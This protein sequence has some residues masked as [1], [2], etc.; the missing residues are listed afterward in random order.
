MFYG[1]HKKGDLFT[2]SVNTLLF[3]DT[4][5]VNRVLKVGIHYVANREYLFR[6]VTVSL[7]AFSQ[8]QG[9]QSSSLV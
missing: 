8:V 5:F 4:I 2:E 6:K 3:A 9:Q 1:T 7:K